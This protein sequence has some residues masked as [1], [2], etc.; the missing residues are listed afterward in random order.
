MQNFVSCRY[1]NCDTLGLT[2][3]RRTVIGLLYFIEN[4]MSYHQS[5]NGL[6]NVRLV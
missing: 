2:C 6:A 5:S 1:A 4:R 3:V